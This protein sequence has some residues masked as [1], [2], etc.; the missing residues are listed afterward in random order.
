M[1]RTYQSFNGNLIGEA[2]GHGMPAAV[3]LAA[4]LGVTSRSNGAPHAHQ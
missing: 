2:G 1:K 4:Y 3:T